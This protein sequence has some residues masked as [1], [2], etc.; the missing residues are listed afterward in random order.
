MRSEVKTLLRRWGPGHGVPPLL[1]LDLG[2]S[3][4][5]LVELGGDAGQPVLECLAREPLDKGWV[6]DGRI[7]D[8]DAVTKAVRRWRCRPPP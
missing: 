7:E 3:S 8:F 1:V 6:N 2:S 4:V 5:R